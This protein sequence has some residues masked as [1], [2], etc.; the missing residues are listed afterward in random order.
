MA[1]VDRSGAE[2]GRLHEEPGQIVESVSF[3]PDGRLLATTREGIE[4]DGSGGHGRDDLGLGARRGRAHHRRPHRHGRS[5]TR[6]A[7]GSRPAAGSK[8]SPTSGTQ[9]GD[10]VA[11]LAPPAEISALAFSPDGTSV[12]TGHADGTVRLWD[13]E[14]GI[15]QLVLHGHERRIVHV[16]FSPDGSMLASIG[17]DG[18]VRVWALDLDDLIAIANDRLT[19]TLTDDE[20]R[21]YLHVD[22]CPPPERSGATRLPQI[23]HTTADEPAP[24][25]FRL[26]VSHHRCHRSRHEGVVMTLTTERSPE[27]ASPTP[28]EP[29]QS[30]NRLRVTA[31]WAAVVAALAAAGFL[32]LLSLDDGDRPSRI[33]TG[34]VAAEHGSVRAIEHRDDVAVQ[35]RDA[36]SRTVTEHGSVSAI[37]HRDNLAV[38]RRDAM[39][40]TV[41]DHGSVRAIEHRDTLAM[42][43]EAM[44]RTVAD[45]G[46]I[47]AIE[48]RDN[49]AVQRGAM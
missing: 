22:R 25:S 41:A 28:A 12:A 35:R 13:P 5:S 34:R 43:R 21:Q 49:L 26:G 24:P 40:R 1:I 44:T 16:V 20:C 45:H 11:T 33:D 8:A 18:L 29:P 46:S 47:S 4:R 15:E 39:S 31:G 36:M 3:S 17:D 30:P 37:E 10:K 6:P 32:A 19:R 42:Q 2:V 9:T 38:Q 7:R 14:T 48:H 27:T 23:C